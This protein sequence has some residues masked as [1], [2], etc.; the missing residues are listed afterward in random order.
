MAMTHASRPSLDALSPTLYAFLQ[1]KFTDVLF[2]NQ[3]SR[4]AIQRVRDPLNPNRTLTN[5]Q[6]WGEYYRVC[7]PFCNDVG[8]KLWINHM[9]GADYNKKSGRRTD[10]HLAI[11]YK[12]DCIA[13]PERREQLEDL[14]FGPGRRL[15]PKLPIQVGS[16]SFAPQQISAPGKILNLLELPDTAP[17][18][19]YLTSRNFDIELLTN[20]FGVGVCTEPLPQYRVMRGRI[21]IP[22]YFN[23]QLVAWQGRLPT[24]QKVDM[25]YYTAGTKSRALYNYDLACRQDCVVIVEGAPSVWRLGAIGVSLFGKTLS[26]WQENTIATTWTGKPVFIVLDHGEIE[27]IEKAAMQLCR[28]NIKVVPV[29]MPDERD[30]ADYSKDD[31]RELLLAAADSVGVTANLSSLR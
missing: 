30:P 21:Y 8:H 28:H 24:T 26:F 12:N 20:A 9:Y 27:A 29:L 18:I 25:K 31:L 3:G 19:E 7:C 13:S 5:A 1:H 15:L 11:C 16:V 14:I 23:Q 4:A 10:T 22:S 6:E 17:A 2:A